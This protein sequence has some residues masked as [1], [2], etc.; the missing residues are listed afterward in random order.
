MSRK[1]LEKEGLRWVERDI[2]TREQYERI[3]LLYEDKKH[4]IGIL[5]ILGS[6]LVGLGILSFVAANWQD[7]PQLARLAMVILLMVSFY[8]GGEVFRRREHEKLGTAL[9][10]LGYISFGAGIVLVGQMFH[11]VAYDI[12]SFVIWGTA[13]ILLTYI[14]RSRFIYLLSLLVFTIAQYYSTTEFHQ[15]SYAGFALMIAGLGYYAWKNQSTLL[16][17]C[18]SL[19]YVLHCLMLVL[20]NEWKFLWFFVPLMALYT[21]G[22][23][24]K[25]RSTGYALQSVPLAAAFIFGIVMVLSWDNGPSDRNELLAEPLYYITALVVLFAASVAGKL[26]NKRNSSTFEW[27]LAVPF[28]YLPAGISVLYLLALFFFSFYVL[29]RG[30][31]EEWR[32]KINFGTV[33]FICSTMVAYGKLTWDF[34]DKSMFFIFGGLLLLVLSWF[35]NRRNKKFLEEAKGGNHHDQ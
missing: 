19:S 25:D 13:G 17:W 16:T 10:A 32:F 31:I 9:T 28:V 2:V 7:I 18:F 33:L 12:T 1:W 34:M 6:I 15:F 8:G 23:W 30:Y 35:L 29:W 27:I 11:L 5:P 21:V 14:V 22:D 26:M 24:Y 20:D 3:L 4:A